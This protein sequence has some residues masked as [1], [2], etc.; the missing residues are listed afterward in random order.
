MNL[1]IS[2]V[3]TKPRHIIVFN[4]LPLYVIWVYLMPSPS[5]ALQK[6]FSED[7]PGGSVSGSG[8]G[9]GGDGPSF[10]ELQQRIIN[11]VLAL[12]GN[13]RCCDCSG[14]NGQHSPPAIIFIIISNSNNNV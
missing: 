10:R 6:A 5:G 8:P 1:G 4:Y 3:T 11:Y 14:T 2:V 13:S 7:R 9:V 12:P